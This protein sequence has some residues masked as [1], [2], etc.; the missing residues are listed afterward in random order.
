MGELSESGIVITLESVVTLLILEGIPYPLF[1]CRRMFVLVFFSLS[2]LRRSRILSIA[3]LLTLFRNLVAALWYCGR[4]WV[5][6]VVYC[7]TGVIKL[8]FRV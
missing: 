6:D 8:D 4:G 5:F 7:F 3:M 2:H 1:Y